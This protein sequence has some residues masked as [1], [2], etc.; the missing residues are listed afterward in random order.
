MIR[1]SIACTCVATVAAGAQSQPADDN[2]F[3]H[4]RSYGRATVEFQDDKVHA[5]AI[6]DYSQR[7]HGGGWILIQ[8]GIAVQPRTT[9]KRDNFQILMPGGRACS[10][11]KQQQFLADSARITQLRQ[12]ATIFN[13]NVRSIFPRA[14][15]QTRCA[16][17]RSPAR[18][19]CETSRSR[20]RS[21]PSWSATSIS[22]RRRCAGR[23]GLPLRVRRREG[24]RNCRFVSSNRQRVCR[25]P[26]SRLAGSILSG[27][28]AARPDFPSLACA[29][30]PSRLRAPDY[31]LRE[32]LYRVIFPEPAARSL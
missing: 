3:P 30:H 7:N 12:N 16:S 8:T 32:E 11:P 22:S 1:L 20:S 6:Y 21:R 18:K 26:V 9:I 10:P 15:S 2:A 24:A 13:R 27:I 23:W 28:A 31:G 25:L 4:T 29:R 5:V 14:R 17:S 19:R